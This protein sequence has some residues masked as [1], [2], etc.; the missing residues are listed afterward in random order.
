MPGKTGYAISLARTR[1][2]RPVQA[3]LFL[4]LKASNC[5][6][7]V[8]PLEPTLVDSLPWSASEQWAKTR[9]TDL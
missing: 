1:S 9:S 6:C 8:R 4:S 2:P 5:C 7:F 3:Y